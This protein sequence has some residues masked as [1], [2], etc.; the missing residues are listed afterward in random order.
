[1]KRLT[2]KVF[3]DFVNKEF[4]RFE[5]SY[6]KAVRVERT[7]YT[8]DQYECGAC[9]LVVYFEDT[10]FDKSHYSNGSFLCFYSFNKM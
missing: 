9:R 2:S 10:R 3:L 4:E 6:L 5:V 8:Q 1:M 7:R